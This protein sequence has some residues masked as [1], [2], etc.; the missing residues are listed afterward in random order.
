MVFAPVNGINLYYETHGSEEAQALLLINGLGGTCQD[1]GPLIPILSREF[2]SIVYDNRGAGKSD[3]PEPPY[4]MKTLA[5]DA[6]GLLDWLNL[7]TT[8]VFGVSMGGMIAQH[9]ALGF[10]H[11]IEKLVLGCTTCRR[12]AMFC[13]RAGEPAQILE[14]L[15][16]LPHD[17]EK[18]EIVVKERI[19]SLFSQAF[20]E[21][22]PEELQ[23]F[24][25]NV[26]KSDQTVRGYWGQLTAIL[27]HSLCAKLSQIA[28]PTLVLHGTADSLVP[29][30]EGLILAKRIPQ[31]QFVAFEGAG[32]LFY[33]EQ[34]TRLTS[35]V[36]RF[37]RDEFDFSFPEDSTRKH[38]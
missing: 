30:E 26:L 21:S 33:L 7:E 37:F 9:L 6:V 16:P 32:H 19:R 28:V 1:W 29:L 15:K 36:A 4:S 24:L 23:D 11:R 5:A 35:I 8:G 27:E 17:P 34:P 25:L 38:S 3:K 2:F 12:L 20:L 14:F 10:P 13:Q 18:K 31:A 22:H